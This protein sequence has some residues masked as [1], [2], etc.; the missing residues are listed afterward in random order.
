LSTQA[1]TEEPD[2]FV[3]RLPY[4]V[5]GIQRDLTVAFAN[6]RAR[7]LLGATAVRV[8][9]PLGEAGS[10]VDLDSLAEQILSSETSLPATTIDLP[11]GRVL[12]VTGIP[13][14]GE[15]PAVLLI[16]D[17]TAQHRHDRV[18]R[19]FVRNAAHQ[20]RTPLTGIATAVEV[21]Q[22][23]AKDVPE[24]RDRFLGHIERDAARLTRIA[25]GLLVLARA[26]SGE[27]NLRLEVVEL[28]PL[29]EQLRDGAEPA[30]GTTLESACPDGLTA[31]ADPNLLEEAL[32]ELLENAIA[33]TPN[34]TVRLT[35]SELES[36]V[37]IEVMDTGAGVRP[38]HRA[39]IFEPF[40]RVDEGGDGFGLGLAIAAQAARA[41]D[42]ELRA[43]DVPGGG[44]AFTIRLPSGHV[45]R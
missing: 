17:V 1:D 25:R 38:E 40:Y 44:T 9:R 39:R 36:H 26:Q 30:A 18:M 35:A 16:E 24:T 7:N 15:D 2:P 14:R 21:L 33:H 34:G 10:T 22:S 19:E 43:A 11:D 4:A 27:Q 6:Q 37:A 28:Q 45:M 32:A 3:V 5:V 29:L 41:M 12:R 42:G 8:G 20:L 13:A 23:G 31:L